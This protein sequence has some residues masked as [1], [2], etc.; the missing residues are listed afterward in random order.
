[1]K[2][3]RDD[4]QRNFI[5]QLFGVVTIDDA[6]PHPETFKSTSGFMTGYS[7]NRGGSCWLS[8]TELVL[9]IQKICL[10]LK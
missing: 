3:H 1:M 10:S 2:I 7:S 4:F 9:F 8:A 6:V 5:W